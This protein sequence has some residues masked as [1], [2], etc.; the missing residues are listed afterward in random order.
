[1]ARST[2][3]T[4]CLL[5][6]S[7]GCAH[8]AGT[9]SGTAGPAPAAPAAVAPTAGAVA[10]E[11]AAQGSP[12]PLGRHHRP[13]ST[14]SPDAQALFDRGLT[15]AYSFH[16]AAAIRSFEAAV[17]LDPS[18]A[19]CWWGIALACGPHINNPEVPPEAN[20]AALGALQTARAVATTG[21]ERDYVEALATRY[22]PDP[23]ADRRPLDAAYAEAMRRL[24]ARRPD[25][26]DAAV[27][28]T[29]ALMN[30]RP[31]DLWTAEGAPQPGTTEIVALLEGVLSKDPDHPGANHLYIHAVEASPHPERAL[32]AADRLAGGLVP[33]VG[34]MVHMPSHV[35]MR[36]GRYDDAAEA[37]RRAIRSDRR[38]SGGEQGF[39]AFYKAHNFQ[40]LAWAAMMEGRSAE[41]IQAS[42]DMLGMM[43]AEAMFAAGGILLEMYDASASLP[44]QALARFGRWDDVLAEPPPDARLRATTAMW[45]YARGLAFAARGRVADA[46]GARLAFVSAVVAVP[47]EATWFNNRALDVLAIARDVLD[48]SIAQ[49]RGDLVGAA[50]ALRRGVSAEDALRYDEPSDWAQQPV[51]QRLGALLLD[52]GRAEEA[53]A[54]FR[55]DL[56][57]N[58][59]NGWS[60]RGLELALRA[61][62]APE[63]EDVARRF[64]TA[65]ARADVS[66]PSSAF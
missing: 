27:L 2:C 16:H 3:W 51:R 12:V 32:A 8:S 59:G 17:R 26:L 38:W 49:R 29:E 66:L 65:W 40:F 64:R 14:R 47:P 4:G 30:L 58:P 39:Y 34:H 21:A 28:Y 7:L 55:E 52:G 11:P 10:Q 57:R 62:G 44:L 24:A 19:M 42:R 18:C 9:T 56:R 46:E 6:A 53:E 50:A 48:A 54:V 23:K 63:A 20:A 1:M 43:P 5:L 22:A 35:Y 13:V 37:N 41:A 31:W 61:R 15:L 33:G 45:H 25:D 60:L 36:V